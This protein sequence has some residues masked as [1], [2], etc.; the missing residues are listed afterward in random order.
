MLLQIR[1]LEVEKARVEKWTGNFPQMML[2]SNPNLLFNS[3]LAPLAPLQA[4]K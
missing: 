3:P 4:T 2:G 1:A